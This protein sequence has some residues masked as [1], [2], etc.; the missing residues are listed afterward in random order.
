MSIL[1]I[2]NQQDLFLNSES[3]VLSNRD[4]LFN[5]IKQNT[6][7][8]INHSGG[9]D[10]Q[11]MM[12]ELLKIIPITNIIVVHA[13]LGEMEWEGALELAQR[14]ADDASI[15]FYIARSAKTLLQMVENRFKSRPDIPSWPSAKYRQCTSDLKRDPIAKVIRRVMKERGITRVI[16]CIGLRAGESRARAKAKTWSITTRH[17]VAGRTWIEYLPIHSFTT[18]DVFS[19][20]RDAGQSPHWAYLNGNQRLSCVFCIMGSKSDLIHGARLNPKLYAKYVSLEKK[21]GYTMHESRISLIDIT[22]IEVCT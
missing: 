19:V 18:D 3:K 10:S 14:Q 2:S 21:T 5:E 1:S 9:K 7:F 15:P 12:I 20:I 13:S 8:V 11:A 22:G 4:S 17:C 16:N 6:L